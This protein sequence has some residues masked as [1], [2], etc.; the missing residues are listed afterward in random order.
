MSP[1]GVLKT[2]I[3]R[4]VAHCD[5]APQL[6]G[7]AHDERAHNALCPRVQVYRSLLG[8]HARYG[9]RPFCPALDFARLTLDGCVVFRV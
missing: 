2:G 6:L 5:I 7:G 8:L 9:V 4:G 3:R 1:S